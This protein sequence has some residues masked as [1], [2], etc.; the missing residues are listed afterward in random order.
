MSA[1]RFPTK[2]SGPSTFT[3][4]PRADCH[5]PHPRSLNQTQVT[6]QSLRSPA[7]RRFCLLLRVCALI[8]GEMK[9]CIA[10]LG[11]RVHEGGCN[12]ATCVL[13]VHIILMHRRKGSEYAAGSVLYVP[14][15]SIARGPP[16]PSEHPGQPTHIRSRAPHETRPLEDKTRTR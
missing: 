5:R 16:S 9:L 2:V 6:G 12:K 15:K 3:L 1:T 10:T 8:Y 14:E 7:Q 4:F 13:V 11:V